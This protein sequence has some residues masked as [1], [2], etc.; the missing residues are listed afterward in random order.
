[1]T[2]TGN[3]IEKGDL[4]AY[5]YGEADLGVRQRVDA[6]LRGCVSCAEDVRSLEAVRGVLGEWVP[7]DTHLGYRVTETV[8]IGGGVKS[9]LKYVLDSPALRVAAVVLLGFVAAVAVTRPEIYFGSDWMLVRFGSPQSDNSYSAEADP[10]PP[11]FGLESTPEDGVTEAR[12][13]VQRVHELIQ[14]S[15]QR[16]ARALSDRVQKVEQRLE[17]QRQAALSGMERGFREVDPEESALA[18]QQLFDYRRSWLRLGDAGSIQER[19]GDLN[20]VSV[21]GR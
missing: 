12:E 1:M 18:R 15:E 6:H 8:G 16:Q 20:R 4:V 21:R 14:E 9:L 2:E 3:C 7:P 17:E 10:L 13:W 19:A 5:L 11:Q